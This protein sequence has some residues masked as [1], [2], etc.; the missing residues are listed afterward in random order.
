MLLH[1]KSQ[2]RG[3][4][5]PNIHNA[6]KKSMALLCQSGARVKWLSSLTGATVNVISRMN[7]DLD[8]GSTAFPSSVVT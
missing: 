8:V 5:I 1:L 4:E 7:D 6:S 2:D 3:H